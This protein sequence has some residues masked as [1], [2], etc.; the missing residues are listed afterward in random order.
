MRFSLATRIS[1]AVVGVVLLALATS[2][3][4]FYATWK[5]QRLL[6]ITV[7]ENLPSVRAA[8]ELEIALL[9]Q[10]G[11]VGSFIL[12]E[13]NREWLEQLPELEQRF[14]R[15]LE[16][17][18]NT[19]TTSKEHRIL[20]QLEVVY[21]K[22]D[23][24]RAHV[25]ALFDAGDEA[26]ARHALLNDV[27]ELYQQ[28]YD[29][30]EAFIDANF[31]YVSRS[32]ESATRQMHRSAIVSSVAI[33]LTLALGVALLWLFFA[34]VLFPLRRMIAD[35]Q[36]FAGRSPGVSDGSSG[37]ELHAIGAYLRL[38][39]S[40]MAETRTSLEDSRARLSTAEKLASVGRLA[41]SI[42]HEI[43]NPLTAVKMWLFSIR[44]G[45][46]G[47][48]GMERKLD[49]VSEEINRL[50]EIIHDFLD[51]S[52]PAPLKLERHDLR[53]VVRRTLD[54]LAC[55]IED[56]GIQL[57]C[58]LPEEPVPAVADGSQL[59]QVLINLVNNAID[60][61]ADGGE[62]YVDLGADRDA[63]GRAIHILR[64]R[65]TGGG[66]PDDIRDRIF[67]PFFTTKEGGTGLGLSIAAQIIARH[68][69]RLVLESTSECG[70]TFSV[71]IP[72]AEEER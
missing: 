4:A 53:G 25:I 5:I 7:H 63:D 35:A 50:E 41:T 67:D 48:S 39:M 32:I 55:R 9:E 54:L 58:R 10:R 51:F 8:E 59:Q 28:A 40:D 27:Y 22:Y 14:Y 12:D 3:A 13:G 18:R 60:A 72:A 52:R 36:G 16:E 47:D 70:T 38:L 46:A 26:Q 34:G 11:R 45:V 62:I 29:L 71:C 64:V 57:N 23:A 68:Q 15:W 69:G 42:A 61:S 43:R 65:D 20:D 24:E 49:I 19:A 21:D 17:A 37:D 31:R 30:C 2:L 33:A 1:A 6:S 56:R 44:S 66:M